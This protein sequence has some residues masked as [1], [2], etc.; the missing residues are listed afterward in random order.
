MIRT[1]LMALL[2][3]TALAGCSWF[4]SPTKENIEPPAELTE[5]EQR[6]D[7]RELWQR[8]MG[9]GAGKTGLSLRPAYLDGT[10]YAS[11]SG[12]AVSA[13]DAGSGDAGWTTDLGK[14]VSSGPGVGDGLV[15]VG[16]LDGAV[17]ALDAD[18][19]AERWRAQVSSEVIATPAVRDGLVVV[20]VHDGRL[21]G[22][23]SSDGTR[24]WVFDR[25]MP[26]LSLRGNGA[27]I[28]DGDSVYAG[29]DNG[30]IIALKTEDGALKWEQSVAQS[31]GRTELER[32]IDVDGEMGFADGQLYAVTYRGQ[33]GAF[34]ADSGRALWTRDLS[35]YGGLALAG[36][37][38]YVADSDGVLWALDAGTGTTVWKQ[39]GLLHR[40][41]S[42]PALVGG[43]V[44]VG[45]F[46]GYVHWYDAATGDL[47][48]RRRVG[49]D[50][51]RAT[52]LAIGDSVVVTNEDG[53]L[54]AFKS[55]GG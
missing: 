51:I 15:V 26:L 49:K 28:I 53:E 39:G 46:K 38:V 7:V 33:I 22:L 18:S 23:A 9:K 50:F 3:V 21:Y 40:F 19:G 20:R 16:T 45:D 25:G 34:A 54:A 55:P 1:P 17:V 8:D 36:D 35:A 10:V 27:P 30:K 44:V 31:E 11:D 13:I 42:T 2:A 14:G 37:R 12:G 4:K 32:M 52:P 24:R 5:F 47:L 29:Y 41:L 6:L 43:Q 48:A